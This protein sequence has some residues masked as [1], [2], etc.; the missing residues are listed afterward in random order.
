MV[1]DLSDLKKAEVDPNEPMMRLLKCRR[2]KTV[3]EVPGY[4]GP[5]G[6]EGTEEFDHLLKFF[7]D[8][9]KAKGCVR[10]DLDL[11]TFP[12]RFWV[13]PKVKE[14]IIAQLQQGAEGLDV[15]GTNFYATKENFSA[16]AMTC[17]V[18]EH[19]QTKDCSDY[20]SEKKELKPGTAKERMVAGLEKEGRGP[21]VYLCD[22]CPVKSLIQVKAYQKKGLYK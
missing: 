12:V 2:C 8:Q 17:W 18:R 21:K 5:D 19:N 15:F 11:I 20:K 10:D 22:F 9:H 6:G 16:D 7:T 3:D 14:G 1:M 13:I 4:D